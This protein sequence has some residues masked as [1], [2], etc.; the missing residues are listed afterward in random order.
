[1]DVTTHDLN[2]DYGAVRALDHV[3]LHIS[4]GMFGLLGP[5]GAGKTTLMRILATL[6]LPTH[7][8]AIIGGVDVARNPAWVRE[9]LGYIPQDFGFYKTLNAYELLDYVATMKNVPRA[10]R[11][12]QV[13]TALE[14]VNLTQDAH[15]RVGTYSGG[16]KQRLG[17]AQA[18]LG[19]PELLVVDEPTA[20]LD[21]EERIRFRNLL[22]QIARRHT[23]MLSTH[24]VGDIEA[25]CTA[26]G[27]LSRGRLIFQGSPQMLTAAA[28][29]KVWQ[30]EA[31]AGDVAYF[32]DQYSVLASVA[33]GR[34]VQLRL[35]SSSSPTSDAQPVSPTLE[36]GYV[37]TMKGLVDKPTDTL[38]TTVAAS[39]PIAPVEVNRG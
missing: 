39:D 23:V 9:H 7:G 1:M 4:G 20:G 25:S 31:E 28:Q 36:D 8:R 37:A 6:T 3:S 14:R 27:V 22:A 34:C 18:L 16:M 5:N 10:A 19:D 2:K 12:R 29:G 21:P 13:E 33:T 32:E 26:V 24:I 38:A 11:R 35:L 15:R 30:V 17:I